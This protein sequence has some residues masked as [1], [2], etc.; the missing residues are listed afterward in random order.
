[1]KRDLYA[2]ASARIV[3]ELERGAT[4]W[5]KS[6]SAMAGMNTPCNAETTAY[7]LAATWPFIGSH[8]RSWV[9]PR[10]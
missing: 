8:N 6:W 5:V 4:P 10:F 1:M 9:P 2:D 7:N 3:S